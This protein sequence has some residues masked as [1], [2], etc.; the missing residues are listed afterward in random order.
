M[1]HIFSARCLKPAN[2]QEWLALLS[3]SMLA[4]L[5]LLGGCATLGTNVKGSFRCEA[6]DGICAP[7]TTIDDQA[8]SQID[9]G[10]STQLLLPSGPYEIDQGGAAPPRRMAK[11]EPRRSPDTAVPYRL[12]VVFPEYVD[13]RGERHERRL[14]E[15]NVTL[16]GRGDVLDALAMRGARSQRAPGLLDAAE[17]APPLLAQAEATQ[18]K[19]QLA[20][21]SADAEP[22]IERIKK[23]VRAKLANAKPRKQAASFPAVVE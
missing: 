14:V 21:D 11:A 18:G 2:R 5:M 13:V 15:A 8:L 16:P 7:S 20:D 23:E 3:P 9:P 1:S 4:S 10:T 22:P 12:T 6:P 19:A 17:Q